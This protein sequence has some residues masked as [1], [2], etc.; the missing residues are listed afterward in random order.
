[1]QLLRG[2]AFAHKQGLGRV[3]LT[4]AFLGAVLGVHATLLLLTGHF[5]VRL[6]AAYAILLSVFHLGEFVLT[7]HGQPGGVTTDSFLLNHSW[8]YGA[9]VLASWAEFWLVQAVA[10]YARES[11]STVSLLGCVLC[12]AGQALRSV[13]MYQA[14]VSF[15]HLVADS[16]RPE[17]LLV[18]S[19]VYA[20]F[21][22]PAYLGWFC[23]SV[24]TQLLLCNPLCSVIY[25]ATSWA[26][27]AS[28]IP[29]E[30]ERLMDFFGE[31]YREYARHS[32]IGIPFVRS[33][34]SEH[35]P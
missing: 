14:G 8:A 19:G 5:A 15:T 3:A 20:V 34:A 35:K 30:E 32:I 10:P 29:G 21:R 1:M 9:A 31:R 27:F 25:S 12:V 33:P 13:A 26:F 17:H 7:A 11:W 2:P 24:G 28:R 23:W 6:W 4:A 16:R 18:T 22:H